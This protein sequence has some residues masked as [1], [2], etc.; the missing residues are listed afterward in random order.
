MAK[1]LKLE[2]LMYNTA[3]TVFFVSYS[4][5]EVP[6]NMVLKMVRPSLWLGGIMVAWG[7]TMTYVLRLPNDWL[8]C[9]V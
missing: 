2:G 9:K 7:I 5:F 8:S 6:S 4:L 1:D 3:L